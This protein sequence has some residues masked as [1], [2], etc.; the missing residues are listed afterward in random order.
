MRF[1]GKFQESAG[2]LRR[3]RTLALAGLFAALQIVTSTV[4]EI[5]IT[6]WL[7]VRFDF[8][9]LAASGMLF[10]PVTAAM[11]GVAADLIGFLLRPASGPFFPGY[12]L[13]ALLGGAIY[14]VF[15]YRTRVS[16][17][18]AL[19]TKVLVNLVVN[20]GLNTL[21]SVM[22]YHRGFWAMIPDRALKNTVLLAVE[23]PLLVLTDRLLRRL[24][25]R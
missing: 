23:V 16:W 2:E 13:S 20:L 14:G 15:F 19:L 22:L 9:F 24:R 21:W 6:P 10:G 5:P 3:P 18:R 25:A 7:R 11:Q 8:V 1:W 4:A 17:P 12:T